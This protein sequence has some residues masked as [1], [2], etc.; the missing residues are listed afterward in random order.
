[1]IKKDSIN[2]NNLWYSIGVIASDGNLSPDERHINITSKDEGLVKNIK[3]ALN[4]DNKIGRKARKA[5]EEKKYYVLQFGDVK[6]YNFLT[7]IGLK[8]NKSISLGK[9]NV[10]D[11][12]FFDFLRGVLDG[13][14]CINSWTHTYNG[15]TQWS[16]RIYSGAYDFASW[17]KKK[18][19]NKLNVKGRMHTRKRNDRENDLYIIK[20]GKLASQVILKEC[21]YKNSLAL[22]RKL[23]KAKK[24]IK[25]KNRLSKYGNVVNNK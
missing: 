3:N 21:Y 13:D 8:S 18:I 6:F 10:P 19:E 24:C 12:F 15:N 7:K 4:L 20:F 23:K 22:E 16:T 25:S 17:V 5:G 2:Q 14:G 1:M 9:I 11:E